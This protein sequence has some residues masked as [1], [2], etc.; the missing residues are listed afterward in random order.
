VG[1]AVVQRLGDD[2]AGS[3]LQGPVVD[4]EHPFRVDR[5]GQEPL[6]QLPGLLRPGRELVEIGVVGT[7]H[8]G[9][10]RNASSSAPFTVAPSIEVIDIATIIGAPTR[11]DNR[12]P[13]G[14]RAIQR[15]HVAGSRDREPATAH[16][17]RGVEPDTPL[18]ARR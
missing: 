7:V 1:V 2:D 9:G 12:F 13:A 14:H 15:R 8:P 11:R 3:D 16:D 17:V 18:R 10:W 6:P 4:H 5:L